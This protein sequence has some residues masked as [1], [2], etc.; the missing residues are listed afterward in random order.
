MKQ[1][2]ALCCY[3]GQWPPHFHYW[4][5]SCSYNID[6][7]FILVSNISI[8]GYD[9]PSNV[10][11]VDMSFAE[12]Q[13]LIGKKFPDIAVSLNRPY[14]LCDF[15]TAYGYIFSDI[16]SSYDYWGYFD[17]DTIWGKITDFIPDNSDNHLL[18][19]FPCGHLS[20]IRNVAPWSRIYEM[21]NQV[22]GT[23]CRNNMEGK[24]VASW[25][26]CFSSA[27]SFYYDEEGG[28]EPMIEDMVS[29]GNLEKNDLYV[30]VDFDNILPPWR[31]NHFYSINSPEKS[32]FLVYR[33][34]RGR[35]E[36]IFLKGSQLHR[37]PISYLHFSKRHMSVPCGN[38]QD[39][40][41]SI[42]PNAF[43]RCVHWNIIKVLFYGRPRY[44]GNLL[45]RIVKR[46]F[47]SNGTK[48]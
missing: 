17:I 33:F 29:K 34:D 20:F 46:I 37:E 12:V 14:K 48:N 15:K 16:F 1:Y 7:D 41:Y 35:L 39:D 31:F 8:Q 4:L 18:K 43:I 3:F 13:A 47:D 26:T 19:I 22:E 30:K 25:Q 6:I 5:K 38:N 45:N 27:N 42:V 11:V 28:L 23:P 32:K 21:V 40:F 10:H 24:V 36:R 2:S 9:V 44:F